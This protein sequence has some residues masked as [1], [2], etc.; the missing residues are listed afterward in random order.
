MNPTP[1]AWSELY[2]ALASG[3]VDGACA[4]WETIALQQMYTEAPYIWESNHFFQTGFPAFN[5]EFWNSLSE[6]D[7]QMFTETCLEIAAEQRANVEKLDGEYKEEILN[8]GGNILARNDFADID[9]VIETYQNGLWKDM[10]AQAD[11]QELYEIM[12]DDTGKNP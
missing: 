1:V 5:L 12:C 3:I 9:E 2:T 4:N 6:E 11:A 10:V 8:N 7:Q